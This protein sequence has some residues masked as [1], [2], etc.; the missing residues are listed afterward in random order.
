MAM[1]RPIFDYEQVQMALGAYVDAESEFRHIEDACRDANLDLNGLDGDNPI[2]QAYQ[3]AELTKKL[4][5][6]MLRQSIESAV[7]ETLAQARAETGLRHRT[8]T[9]QATGTDG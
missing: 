9:F 4:A 7:E 3:N 1:R 8:D 6:H 2:L 5:E